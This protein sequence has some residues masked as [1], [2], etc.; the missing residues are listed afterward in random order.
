MIAQSAGAA[1]FTNCISAE[2]WDPPNEFPGY[3]IK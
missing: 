3:D 2:E 1:E